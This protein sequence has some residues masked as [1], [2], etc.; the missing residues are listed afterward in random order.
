MF[1]NYLPLMLINQAVGL[2]LLAAY[3]CFGLDR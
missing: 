3:V 2:A 1:I